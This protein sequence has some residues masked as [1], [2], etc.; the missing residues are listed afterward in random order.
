MQAAPCTIF[1]RSSIVHVV[2]L[3]EPHQALVVKTLKFHACGMNCFNVGFA[4]NSKYR[5]Q[6]LETYIHPDTLQ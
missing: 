6:K 3:K 2:D 1:S 5:D 4:N